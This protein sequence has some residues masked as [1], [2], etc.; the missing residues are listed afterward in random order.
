M[1]WQWNRV[2]ALALSVYPSVLPVTLNVSPMSD[3]IQKYRMMLHRDIRHLYALFN[4]VSIYTVFFL[5]C[6]LVL[7]ETLSVLIDKTSTN[8]YH[9]SIYTLCICK[10][11]DVKTYNND[12]SDLYM[13]D[14][15]STLHCFSINQSGKQHFRTEMWTLQIGIFLYFSFIRIQT[16][17]DISNKGCA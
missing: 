3:S 2:T 16:A 11:V 8:I 1:V 14:I 13:L 10:V 12:V 6:V 9:P 4:T 15:L 17:Y 5:G 7:F